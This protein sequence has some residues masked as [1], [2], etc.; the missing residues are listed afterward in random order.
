MAF[1]KTPKTSKSSKSSKSS[2]TARVEVA[3]DKS[4]VDAIDAQAK[5]FGLKIDKRGHAILT[6]YLVACAFKILSILAIL[7]SHC[8]KGSIDAKDVQHLKLLSRQFLCVRTVESTQFQKGGAET[9]MA[10]EYFGHNSGAYHAAAGAFHVTELSTPTLV[11]PALPMSGGASEVTF[12]GDFSTFTSIPL[13]GQAPQIGGATV[14][15]LELSKAAFE[16]ILKCKNV[17][18]HPP[19]KDDAAAAVRFILLCNLLN[20]LTR[21]KTE[22]RKTAV[23]R[24]APVTASVLKTA[25][26]HTPFVIPI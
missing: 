25:I 15:G 5:A 6:G 12:D 19:F 26:Q 8:D 21:V 14:A 13:G 22:R 9:T 24:G 20:L 2:K 7:A 16:A 3:T 17:P 4:I 1:S 23:K 18:K 11:R 10:S